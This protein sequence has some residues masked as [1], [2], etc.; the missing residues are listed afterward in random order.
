MFEPTNPCI[1]DNFLIADPPL[2][3]VCRIPTR[4]DCAARSA[5]ARR[6][7]N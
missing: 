2:K 4:P 1:I 7:G 3:Q 6:P 5:P